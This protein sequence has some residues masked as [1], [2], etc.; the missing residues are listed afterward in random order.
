[1]KHIEEKAGRVVSSRR[2][3]L[4]ALILWGSMIIYRFGLHSEAYFRYAAGWM[5]LVMF[6]MAL[7]LQGV[8]L[9]VLKK[10]DDTTAAKD[11]RRAGAFFIGASVAVAAE[12]TAV[13]IV[14]RKISGFSVWI[15]TIFLYYF[16]LLFMARAALLKLCFAFIKQTEDN[17]AWRM[18]AGYTDFF[19]IAVHGAALVIK[20]QASRIHVAVLVLVIA[21]LRLAWAYIPEDR[22]EVV[23]EFIQFLGERKLW[24]MAPIFIVM[25]FLMILVMLTQTTGGSFP[26]IY[27]VF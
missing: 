14:E 6:P 25:A 21:S 16:S 22:F 18:A 24:W 3:Y 19:L 4:F 10:D 1:M 9:R 8:L 23:R 27:A 7:F 5:A 2:I 17:V 15:A 12:L 11:L 26:F 20:S 13:L